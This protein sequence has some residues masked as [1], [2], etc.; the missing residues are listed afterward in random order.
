MT[1]WAWLAGRGAVAAFWLLTWAYGLIVSVRFAFEQFIRPQLFPWVTEFVIW[2]HA[3]YWAA[4]LVTAATLIPELVALRHRR[5]AHLAG[6]LAAAYLLC[7][8]ALG[9]HLLGTP[10]LVTI[11]GGD[12]PLAIVPGALL[13]LLWLALIDHLSAPFPPGGFPRQVTA[14]R[15]LFTTCVA[16]ALLVWC[17]H[18]SVAAFR[19]D[20]SGGVA[21]RSATAVWALSLDVAAALAVCVILCGVTAIAAT[22]RRSFEWEYAFAVALIAVAITEFARRLVL[23]SLT[24]SETEA[25][26]GAVPFGIVVALMWSGWRLRQRRE[27]RPPDTALV[28]LTSLFDGRSVRSLL[29]LAAVPIA[30]L[31]GF[32]AVEQ[33]DWALI[34][35]RTIVSLEVALIFGFFLARFRTHQDDSW[36]TA[37]IVATPLAAL[38]VLALLPYASKAV[39]AMTGNPHLQAEMALDRLPTNEPM[40]AAVARLWIEQQPPDMDYYRAVKESS[41]TRSGLPLQPPSTTYAQ[42]PVILDEPPPN[43]FIFLIDSLRR[44]YL[45]PYNPAVSFTPHIA[46]LA[47]DS[48]VF[49]NAFTQYGGTWMSIPAM[50]TGAPVTRS[51]GQ[52]FRQMNALEPVIKAGNYDF[53]IN[54]YTVQTLFSTPR[55]FLN[56]GV[57][58]VQTDLC[59]NVKAMRDHID[60]QVGPRRPLFTFIAPM[61]V[62]ILNTRSADGGPD[63]PRY[64]GFYASYAAALERLDGCF[65][66]FLTYLQE[67]GLYDNSIIVL[68]SD[69]GESL[70][71]DGN[72]GHQFFLFPEVVQ[73]P[74]MVRVPQNLR[75]RVT[76]DLSRIALL[77]DVGP[78]LLSLLGQPVPDL[79][80]PFGASLFVAPDRTLSARR[81]DSFLLMSSYG[82]SFAVLR[83]NGKFLYISDLVTSREYGYTLFQKPVGERVPLNDTM[84][85][86]G[87]AAIRA[88]LAEVEGIYQPK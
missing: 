72:W 35:N 50:W 8:G 54:D 20:I 22:R 83:R 53:L 13:P 79:S 3:W 80:P 73:I 87:Q 29:L 40:A 24:F 47:A 15:R 48:Y 25:A 64:D 86:T 31:I 63:D 28:I 84:R 42:V 55:T 33:V 81:R 75:G 77:A 59:D 26:A 44:D 88:K 67:R 34:M 43:V 17:V 78:S 66:S 30:A 39:F 36:P 21:G 46:K 7:F 23:P 56:P 61:N 19:P 5:G 9:V 70:G 58:S 1:R 14:P 32:R 2:H 18:I 49:T 51:W 12:R 60:A 41:V 68:A 76:T 27:D 74:M 6:W 11:D 65:G 82:S 57:E 10:F 85:R 38:A 71:T 52:I 69:H 45:S 16:T 4:W 37:R 62:H